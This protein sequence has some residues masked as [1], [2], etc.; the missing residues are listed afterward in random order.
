MRRICTWVLAA[1]VGLAMTVASPKEGSGGTR[2]GENKVD[3][4]DLQKRCQTGSGK[5]FHDATV[6]RRAMMRFKYA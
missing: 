6:P 4:D 1:I 2:A 3:N 5:D